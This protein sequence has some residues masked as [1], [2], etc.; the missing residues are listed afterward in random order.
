MSNF[1]IVASEPGLM[2]IPL[3]RALCYMP[4]F[5][6]F[7]DVQPSSKVLRI[8]CRVTYWCLLKNSYYS[9]TSEIGSKSATH[10]LEIAQSNERHRNLATN[11]A[12]YAMIS[13][14]LTRT[15]QRALQHVHGRTSV[16]MTLLDVG[17]FLLAL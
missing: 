17:M 11:S 13:E 4:F 16:W 10:T 15:V 2:C 6:F 14:P 12:T 3:L 7:S 8:C 1:N 5:F 9:E